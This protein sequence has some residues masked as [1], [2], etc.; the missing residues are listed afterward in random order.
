MKYSAMILMLLLGDCCET[1]PDA[2]LPL[3]SEGLYLAVSVEVDG[4]EEIRL[5]H[6]GHHFATVVS[7]DGTF[8]LRFH[9]SE[10]PDSWGTSIYLMPHLPAALLFGASV[11]VSCSDTA[12]SLHGTGLV[13]R[14]DS[15]AYGT[16]DADLDVAFDPDGPEVL[17]EGTLLISL[18]GPLDDSTGDLAVALVAS[19][20]L[21][22][23]ALLDGTIGDTGDMSLVTVTGDDF[24]FTWIPD[25]LPAHFPADTTTTLTLDVAGTTNSVDTAAMGYAPINEAPKPSVTLTLTTIPPA[26]V[27]TFGGLYDT[28]KAQD[29]WEDSVGITPLVRAAHP[30]GELAFDVELSATP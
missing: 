28:T 8:N 24:A 16:W 30:G 25:E 9:P 21:S 4:N 20:F 11:V 29:F 13:N 3:C 12:V 22:D 26:P 18:D 1:A 15:G 23:V 5:Y 17:A 27:L 6:D 7:Q 14:G 2:P 10:N 19:N